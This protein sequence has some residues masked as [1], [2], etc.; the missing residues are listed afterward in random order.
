MILR[1][2]VGCCSKLPSKKIGI[3]IQAENR[4][5]RSTT[6]TTAIDGGE[7]EIATRMYRMANKVDGRQA[8][9][10]RWFRKRSSCIFY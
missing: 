9:S 2:H 3:D 8:A 10:F 4:V 6:N 5:G 1:I 7:A